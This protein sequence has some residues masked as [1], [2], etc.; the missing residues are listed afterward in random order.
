MS[1]SKVKVA[2]LIATHIHYDAETYQGK[3]YPSQLTLFVKCLNH[4]QK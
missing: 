4:Y 1:N 3:L 2:I